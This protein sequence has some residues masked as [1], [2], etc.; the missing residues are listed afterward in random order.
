MVLMF[1]KSTVT[2]WAQKVINEEYGSSKAKAEIDTYVDELVTHVNEVG[3]AM[4]IFSFVLFAS[5][6]LGWCYR[7]STL[8]RT[9]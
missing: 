1:N 9:F 8:E 4:L 3:Y 2:D 6:F 5:A 7:N